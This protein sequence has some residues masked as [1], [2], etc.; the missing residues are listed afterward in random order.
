MKRKEYE[1]ILASLE[2]ALSV[3]EA[4]PVRYGF[5]DEAYE[6]LKEVKANL[7]QAYAKVTRAEG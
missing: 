6:R 3:F 5:D 4:Q 2:R 7:E 1:Q